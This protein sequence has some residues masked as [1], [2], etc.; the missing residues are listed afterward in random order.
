MF[1]EPI[2]QLEARLRAQIKA[3][4]TLSTRARGEVDKRS[5]GD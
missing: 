4:S 5:A 2:R 3:C 1:D